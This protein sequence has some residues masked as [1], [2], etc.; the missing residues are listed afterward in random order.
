[1]VF[2]AADLPETAEPL[3][4]APADR[5]NPYVQLD[6]P[7]GEQALAQAEA[8]YVGEPIAAVVGPDAY[9]TADAVELVRVAY[10]A[11]PAVVDAEAAMRAGS[12]EVHA[13]ASNIVGRIGKVIGDVER[14]FAEAEVGGEDHPAQRPRPAVRA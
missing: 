5:T 8:R 14:A 13:G 10:E 1:M 6:T 9:S 4:A 7:R 2:T 11:L 3:P 12:P